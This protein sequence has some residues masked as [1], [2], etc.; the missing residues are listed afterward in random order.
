MKIVLQIILWIACIGFGYLIYSS[1]N[2]PI[3]FA[4]VKEERFQKVINTLKDIRNSQEAYKSSKGEYAK[5]F[6]SLI[7]FVENGQYTITQ[8]RDTSFLE[9]NEQFGIDML[10]EKKIIDTLGFVSVKDSLFKKDTRYKTMMNVPEAANG[11]KFTM[12]AKKI[13]KSGFSAA[14]FEAKVAKEVVLFDQPKDLVAR[15]KTYVN[16]EE[17]NG[18]DIKVGSLEEVSTNGNWPPIYDKKD[19]N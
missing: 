9:F 8:Q 3:E 17:V 13:D 12:D 4:N 16:V 15:E 11:E 19:R 10:V 6:N 2:A 1:V 5:D 14:V 18:P 7:S